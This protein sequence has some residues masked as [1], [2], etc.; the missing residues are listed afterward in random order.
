VAAFWIS[1]TMASLLFLM[2]SRAISCRAAIF[3]GLK[4][5]WKVLYSTILA[6]TSAS[7][8]RR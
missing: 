2:L 3:S 1:L 4:G 7:S 8:V 6:L 5:L